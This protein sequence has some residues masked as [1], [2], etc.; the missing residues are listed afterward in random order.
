MRRSV[1]SLVIAVVLAT[2]TLS[3]CAGDPAPSVAQSGPSRSSAASSS[4]ALSSAAPSRAPS[5]SAAPSS[6][7]SSSAAPSGAPSS[8]APSSSAVSS[9]AAPS[10][11]GPVSRPSPLPPTSPPSTPQKRGGISAG[12]LT[13]TGTIEAGVEHGCLVL[14]DDRTKRRVNLSGGNQDIVKAGATV[15]VVGVIRG[16]MLSY[17]QQGPIFQVLQATAAP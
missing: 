14:T 1:S 11:L 3:G 5:S 6:A 17:C 9:I 13:L 8:S 16:D 10:R 4:A 12:K 2:G 15:T 7:P